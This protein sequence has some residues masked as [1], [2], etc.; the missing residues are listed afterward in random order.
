MAEEQKGTNS[1]P[2]SNA[3]WLPAFVIGY[4]LDSNAAPA[5]VAPDWIFSFEHQ[6][7]HHG[8][9]PVQLLGAVLSLN[10]NLDEISPSTWRLARALQEM[11]E[12]WHLDTAQEVE[13]LR[14]EIIALV[15]C[16][17]DGEISNFSELDKLLADHL[18]MFGMKPVNIAWGWEGI[19]AF[20]SWP[21]LWHYFVNWR[22]TIPTPSNNDGVRNQ[23][24]F[25]RSRFD[26]SHFAALVEFGNSIGQPNGPQVFLIWENCD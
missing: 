11:G 15:G 14:D 17:T 8:V 13:P 1:L 19:F 5:P 18:D 10:T 16:G 3:S 12:S 7:A 20:R 22:L 4:K 9:I 6:V 24:Y 26:S 21:R 2:C 23:T 25:V